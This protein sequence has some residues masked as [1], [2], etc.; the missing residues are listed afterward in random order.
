MIR[1]R[2]APSPTG[3]LHIGG[4]RTALFSWAFARKNKGSFV[5]RIEDTDLERSTPESVKAI[6]DGMHWVGLDYDEGPFYQTQRFDRYKAVIRQLLDAGH[7][8]L[9]Y[10][11]RE[12]LEAL[13]AGQEE[14]GEKPRYDRRWRPEEGKV[15]PPPPAGVEPVVRFRTPLSGVVAWEDAVKGRIEISNE[16]LDDLIIARPDGSPTYNFCVVVD[17]WDMQI[18]HVIRGDDH[19]NNTPRQINILQA[20]G[21]PL[22]VYGHLPMILNADGQKMSKRRDA[23]SVVD[24]AERGILP[25][26]LLNYLARLGWGHGDDEL[27]DMAQFVEWFDLDAVSSSPSRFDGEKLLW[28]NAQ[29]LK[30]A[31]LDR[32]AGL[33]APRLAAAGIDTAAGPALGEVIAL[34]RERVQDLNAL[35]LECDYFYRR[36]TPDEAEVAKHLGDESRARMARFAERLAALDDWSAASIHELFK[37]FCSEEGIKMGLL[38]MPLRILVCGTAH[39]PSV[40]AVLALIGKQQVLERMAA[41]GS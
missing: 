19:V 3:F 10:C 1:T 13:R 7:A 9:C 25:E 32:L 31:S 11:S 41:F 6:L 15:L 33:V 40:D 28:L 17:D 36:R 38:G 14:R 22:P 26:A 34:L 8:Y 18:T 16:E 30:S 35:A 4:V 5:L 21:A 23:V 27:F 24:Y 39:T 37:P 20:L 29:Y 12:E 2:F